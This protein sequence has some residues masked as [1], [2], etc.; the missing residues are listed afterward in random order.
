M[1]DTA[2]PAASVEYDWN[3]VTGRNVERL[4]APKIVPVPAPI[5]AQA[6]ASWDEQTVKGHTFKTP[7]QAKAFADLMK[8]AGHHTKPPTSVRAVID[9]DNTGNTR[10]VHWQAGKRRGRSAA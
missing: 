6:Q 1:A 7:E 10:L 3:A 8:N 9:P 2:T 5:V 4:K